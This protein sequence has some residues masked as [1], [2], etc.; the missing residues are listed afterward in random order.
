[1]FLIRVG[2]IL[3]SKVPEKLTGMLGLVFMPILSRSDGERS[4]EGYETT[5]KGCDI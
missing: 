2:E 5:V 3:L 1:L 4:K